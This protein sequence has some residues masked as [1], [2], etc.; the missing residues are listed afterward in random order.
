MRR[1][2]GDLSHGSYYTVTPNDPTALATVTNEVSCQ[3]VEE[4]RTR[5]SLPM[6]NDSDVGVRAPSLRSFPILTSKDGRNLITDRT[7]TG[8]NSPHMLGVNFS[9]SSPAQIYVGTTNYVVNDRDNPLVV[10]PGGDVKQNSLVLSYAEPRAY[11]PDEAFSAQYEGSLF[12]ERPVAEFAYQNGTATLTDTGIVFC[13]RGVDDQR[14]VG[15]R[16]ADPAVRDSLRLERRKDVLGVRPWSGVLR[17]DVERHP[18]R[19]EDLLVGREQVQAAP[20]AVRTRTRRT[21]AFSI[22]RPSSGTHDNSTTLRG[23]PDLASEPEMSS[24]SSR[25]GPRR[26]ARETSSTT[27]SRAVFLRTVS[28]EMQCALL[29]E[30]VIRVARRPGFVT[31]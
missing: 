5:S 29:R 30:W 19:D 21:P 8:L 13:V 4:N 11:A 26:R 25:A 2:P 17:P 20:A 1:R 3:M 12:G 15:T 14:S 22:A 7:P 27:S 28:Y 9:A 10:D 18:G 24:P 16:V 6:R 23:S 31:T